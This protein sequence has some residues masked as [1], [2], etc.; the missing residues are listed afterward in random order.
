M[1]QL[2]NNHLPF[3]VEW[4]HQ[5]QHNYSPYCSRNAEA[6]PDAP[7]LRILEYGQQ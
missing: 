5:Y 7:P 1:Q 6:N 2:E 3:V 4:Q